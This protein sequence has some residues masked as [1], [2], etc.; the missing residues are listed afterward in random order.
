[1]ITWRQYLADIFLTARHLGAFVG[2]LL[3]LLALPG[4]IVTL[5]V[6]DAGA[7]SLP[8]FVPA[9]GILSALLCTLAATLIFLG[10]RTPVYFALLHW[11]RRHRK[12]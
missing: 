6:R 5:T 10:L 9:F 12:R 1:M 7:A 11:R 3:F 8:W 2:S 4:V